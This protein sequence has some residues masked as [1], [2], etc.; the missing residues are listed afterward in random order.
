MGANSS[1][2]TSKKRSSVNKDVSKSNTCSYESA[3]L[4]PVPLKP[5]RVTLLKRQSSR[6]PASTWASHSEKNASLARRPLPCACF[7]SSWNFFG[8]VDSAPHSECQSAI[9]CLTFSSGGISESAKGCRYESG[10]ASRD[11]PSV[12]V[13]V[14]SQ[15][16]ASLSTVRFLVLFLAARSLAFSLCSSRT[17]G[18]D[19]QRSVAARCLSLLVT[20]CVAP[21]YE[22]Q[23]PVRCNL[24]ATTTIP[25]VRGF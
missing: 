9:S 23:D 21:I 10:S 22:H 1:N 13:R 17:P 4:Y 3:T 15:V 11:I 18:F 8:Q 25:T 14:E 12:L 6:L 2:L 19:S 7:N 20:V 5:L 24:E 16:A